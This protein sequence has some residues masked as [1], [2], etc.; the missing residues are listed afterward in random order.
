LTTL[1]GASLL[2]LAGCASTGPT[3]AP[4]QAAAQADTGPRAK[5]VI[6]FLGD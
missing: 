4:P 1:A 3:Q 5:N 2:L 6:F